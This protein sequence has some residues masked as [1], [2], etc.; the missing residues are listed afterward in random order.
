[1]RAI[2]AAAV[3]GLLA[4]VAFGG[5]WTHANIPI[6]SAAS[7]RIDGAI[8]ADEYGFKITDP[9]TGIEILAAADSTTLYMALKSPGAGWLAI[10]FGSSG[11]NGSVMV[12]ALG[13]G[14]GKWKVE[15]H[16]GRSF[17]RHSPVDKPN[18]VSAAAWQTDGRTCMEFAIPRRFS[19]DKSVSAAGP[20]PFILA[21]HKSNG[22]PSKHSKRSSGTLMLK[23]AAK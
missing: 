23:P 2:I 5:E 13:D 4:G 12:I 9:K 14:R 18:L 17:Y 19:G 3:L 15:Q 22:A 21:Y 6:P 16:Q 11:M 8:G 20:T 1:M 10:G 7:V